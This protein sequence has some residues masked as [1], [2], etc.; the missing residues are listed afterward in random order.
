MI[1]AALARLAPG[2][3]VRSPRPTARL[4]LTMLY[5]ALF[6]VS[7]GALVA[8]TY[9]LAVHATTLTVPAPKGPDIGASPYE[10]TYRLGARAGAGSHVVRLTPT[11]MTR[12]QAQ[13]THLH[14]LA[15]H[16]LL[17]GSAITLAVVAVISIALGWLM[18]G[19]VLRPVRAIN[20]SARRISASTL[21]ER[22]NLDGPRDEFHELAQNLDSLLGRLQASFDSQRRFVANASH[23]LRTPL[24]LDRALLERALRKTEPTHEFWRETCERLLVSNL[25]QERL[26]D[27]LLTL[28]RS[29]AAL[30][31]RE[32]CDLQ[33]LVA[34]VLLSPEL[35]SSHT[36]PQLHTELEPAPVSADSGLLERLIRNLIANAE[37][38]NVPGGWV[39][40]KTESRETGAVLTV[41]N[42]GPVVRHDEV[43]RLLEPFQRAGADRTNR[44]DG[45]GLGLSIVHAIAGAHGAS[46]TVTPRAE[47]GLFVRVSFPPRADRPGRRPR[48][49][50]AIE[51]STPVRHSVS[52]GS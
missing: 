26:I 38:H 21:H 15:M 52:R 36:R 27:A 2:R 47:G 44:S 29:G 17:I 28:A 50:A 6:L 32:P 42:T 4:R 1:A 51:R 39:S 7:G 41:T 35:R 13:L 48:S 23:E 46:L 37:R 20:A 8:V 3:W 34:T 14:Y 40:V 5:G 49:E 18:A 16:R 22:V 19:R 9:L 11:Q 10:R 24:T 31:V 25:H 45:L 33:D 43:E 12:Q 30:D